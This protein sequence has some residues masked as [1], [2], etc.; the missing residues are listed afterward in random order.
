MK[1]S[2]L[3]I[4]VVLM[5]LAGCG[6]SAD[7]GFYTLAS[8]SGSATADVTGSVRITRPALAGYLDRPDFVSQTGDYQLRVNE[9][10]NWAEPL[11]AM[12]GRVLADDLQQRLPAAT[13]VTDANAGSAPPRFAI[14]TSVQQFNPVAGGQAVLRGEAILTD[15][16]A[17]AQPAPLPFILT[18]ATG[19]GSATAVTAALSGLIGQ[20]ADQLAV[21]LQAQASADARPAAVIQPAEPINEPIP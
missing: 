13:V 10:V 17:H 11:D 2:A 14:E 5:A 1:I 20:Y 18:A 4:P 3:V 21:T 7:P 6:T 9:T 12:F 15:R 19:G 16:S 8:M